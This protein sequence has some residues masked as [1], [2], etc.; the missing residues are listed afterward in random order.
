M[1]AAG[2][3]VVGEVSHIRP[4]LSPIA[5]ETWSRFTLSQAEPE[6]PTEIPFDTAVATHDAGEMLSDALIKH[7]LPWDQAEAMPRYQ[8]LRNAHWR[9][10]SSRRAYR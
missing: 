8:L 6:L 10:W 1:P 5:R 3:I 2:G 7:R 9:G 4:H